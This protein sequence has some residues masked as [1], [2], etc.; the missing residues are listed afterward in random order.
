MEEYLKQLSQIPPQLIAKENKAFLMKFFLK[1]QVAQFHKECLS[2]I[3]D[4]KNVL[5]IAP[6]GH[7]KSLLVASYC[8]GEMLKNSNIRIMVVSNTS[9][10]STEFMRIVKETF[11]NEEF[12]N[13]FGDYTNK[14][15]KWTTGELIIRGRTKVMREPTITASSYGGAII[16]RHVDLLICDDII[17]E[18]NART[19][20]QREM[21]STWFYKTLMPTLEPEAK[22][23]IT[24]TR[25]HYDDLYGELMDKERHP[26]FKVLHYK[27]VENPVFNEEGKLSGG[28]PLWEWLW[29]LKNLEDRRSKMG[30]LYWNMQYQNDPSGLKGRL[31]EHDWFQWYQEIPWGLKYY[32]GVDL[33]SSKSEEAH[34]FVIC[35]IGIDKLGNIYIVDLF[36]RQ[37]P[38][39]NDQLNMIRSKANQYKPFILGVETNQ[40]QRVMAQILES[41]VLPVQEIHTSVDIVTR[42]LK[43]QPYIQNGRVFVQ[44]SMNDTLVK[45]CLQVPRGESDDCISALCLAI[46]AA[47]GGTFVIKDYEEGQP[48]R[49]SSEIF[50]ETVRGINEW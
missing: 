12:K 5:I 3:E 6:R 50:F 13:Y 28:K 11:E 7:G 36:R 44:K 23:I 9:T 1:R 24:G 47:S 48:K 40:Y 41:V 17:D 43:I 38:F 33:M 22:L 49:E 16:S 46:E 35:T 39:I 37:L 8:I 18:E 15:V 27:A 34:Y 21:L 25:W 32:M 45:E 30:T 29:S 26:E 31:C 20:T 2:S 42:F 19:K 4:E 14:S 10:Q